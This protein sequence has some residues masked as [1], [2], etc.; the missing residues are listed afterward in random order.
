MSNIIDKFRAALVDLEY[1]IAE[2]DDAVG[3]N[4]EEE[5]LECAYALISTYHRIRKELGLD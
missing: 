2:L 5:I 3:L 4:D 1:D